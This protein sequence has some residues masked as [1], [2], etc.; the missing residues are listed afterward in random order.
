MALGANVSSY[1]IPKSRG[2]PPVVLWFFFVGLVLIVFMGA[3]SIAQAGENHHWPAKD[4]PL[5]QLSG[6]L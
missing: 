4:T 2:V 6:H 5:I 3:I 1:E